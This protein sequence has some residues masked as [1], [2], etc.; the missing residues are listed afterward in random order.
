MKKIW[1]NLI[2]PFGTPSSFFKMANYMKIHNQI[3]GGKNFGPIQRLVHRFNEFPASNGN[4]FSKA[5]SKIQSCS[6]HLGRKVDQDPWPNWS[7]IKIKI[8]GGKRICTLVPEGT[9]F[10]AIINTQ[11]VTS[12]RIPPYSINPRGSKFHKPIWWPI[13]KRTGMRVIEYHLGQWIGFLLFIAWFP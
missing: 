1:I 7:T 6:P 11:C 10:P 5:S 2:F 13:Y 9:Y 12:V 8:K 4:C 3:L